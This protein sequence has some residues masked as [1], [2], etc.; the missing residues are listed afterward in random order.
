MIRV[1]IGSAAAAVVMFVI[2]FVFFGPLGLGNLATRSIDDIPAQQIQQVLRA[3]LAETGT[4]VIPND[5][6]SSEQTRM[7]GTGPVAT[8]HYI[9]GGQVGG[10]DAATALKGLVFNF[11]IALLIGLALIG[12]D[13]RVRDFA[14][15]ARVAAIIGVA[16]AA[17]TDLGLPLYGHFG[18][19]HFVYMFVADALMLAAA[20]VTVAWFIKVPPEPAVASTSDRTEDSFKAD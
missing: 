9:V 8:V 17:F 5:R 1:V 2:G 15:R 19:P 6:K 10:M 7:Y 16:G 18:W 13:G 11:A 3:N 4:Y 12:I 14:S 20:G